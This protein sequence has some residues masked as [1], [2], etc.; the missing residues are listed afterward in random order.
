MQI[1]IRLVRF[2]ATD[3]L[4]SRKIFMA[5]RCWFPLACAVAFGAIGR[6]VLMELVCWPV[7]LVAVDALFCASSRQILVVEGRRFPLCGAVALGAASFCELVQRIV[8]LVVCV[9]SY[10]LVPQFNRKRGV[11]EWLDLFCR[12]LAF[13]VAVALHAGVI[14]NSFVEKN[15]VRFYGERRTSDRFDAN[16][17]L[18]VATDALHGGYATKGR[19]ASETIFVEL[20]VPSAQLTGMQHE[21]GKC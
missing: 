20:L 9:A 5:E 13:V 21:I 17:L 6:N 10:A 19:V 18:L 15:L 16:I 12:P 7:I 1:V 14:S 3:A 11:S 4:F 2:V 8:R